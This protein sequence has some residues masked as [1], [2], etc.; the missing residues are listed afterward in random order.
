MSAEL[1]R[2]LDRLFAAFPL[3]RGSGAAE[4]AVDRSEL[5]L[6]LTFS[7]AYREF[8]RKYGAAMVKSWPVMGLSQVEVMGDDW[9][10]V[11]DVTLHFR[12]EDWPGARAWYVVSID[13]SGNPIGADDQ[14]R[15]WISD[16]DADQISLVAPDFRTWLSG[17]FATA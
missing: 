13:G 3:M 6:G 17:I 16:H 1:W 14:G 10:N 11:V 9:W 8:L 12:R 7:P 2:S 5:A 4:A 15:I